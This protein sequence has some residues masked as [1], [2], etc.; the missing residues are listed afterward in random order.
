MSA[1]SLDVVVIGGGQAG[2]SVAHE[3]ARRG[4]DQV[5]LERDRVASMW[6][7]LWDGFCI[8][9]PPGWNPMASRAGSRSATPRTI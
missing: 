2:L 5:I 8:N 4:V 6:R 1:A 9:R 7:G 3:L